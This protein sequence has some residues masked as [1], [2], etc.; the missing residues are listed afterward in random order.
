MGIMHDIGRMDIPAENWHKKGCL[1][2]PEFNKVKEHC[3]YSYFR[4]ASADQVDR[5][6]LVGVLQHHERLDGS[7]YP[8][9]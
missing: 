5:Q 8:T 2:G 9:A 7:G 1:T 6:S 4:L 3:L